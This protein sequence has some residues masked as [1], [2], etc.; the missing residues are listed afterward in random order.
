MHVVN[1]P[2][3]M[4]QS[5]TTKL[6]GGQRLVVQG[7]DGAFHEVPLGGQQQ[8]APLPPKDKLVKGKTYPTPR[9]NA[10]WDGSQ[11]TPA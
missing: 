10:V 11:F 9:G 2:D 8:P 6:G 5:G 3:M 1:L 4:D 7:A